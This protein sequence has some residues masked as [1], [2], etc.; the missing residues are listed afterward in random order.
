MIDDQDYL[1]KAK[2]FED[3]IGKEDSDEK[4]IAAVHMATVNALIAIAEQLERIA[5]QMEV[6]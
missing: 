3:R 1:Q 5:N 2:Y 4:A 6:R